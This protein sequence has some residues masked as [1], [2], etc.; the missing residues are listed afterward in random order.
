MTQNRIGAVLNCSK[1]IPNY[2]ASS[3]HIEY[4]RIPVDDMMRKEDMHDMSAYIN[5]GV[6]FVYKNRNLDK[7]NVLI[8]CMAGRQ[9]SAIICAAYLYRTKNE[10]SGKDAI[11]KIRK[12]RTEAFHYGQSVNF[13]TC[14]DKLQR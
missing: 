1:D 2:F 8:H 10:K 9:R 11:N 4:M 12:K 14:L 6:S 13:Q 5:H 7:K 3:E